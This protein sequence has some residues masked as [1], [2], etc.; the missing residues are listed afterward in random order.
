M[1]KTLDQ[2]RAEYAFKIVS[3]VTDKEYAS[4]FASLTSKMPSYILTNGLGNTLAFLFSKGKGHH[5]CIAGL[6]ADWILRIYRL[7]ESPN[8]Q[9]LTDDW[10]FDTKKIKNNLPEIMKGLVLS[11]D[12]YQYA[13]VTNE[14]LALFGW[15]KR[16]SD[17]MLEKG[18]K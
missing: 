18:G 14:L 2:R 1:A 10:I 13:V 8:I 9:A 15:L 17:G 5:L 3:Q 7:G 12:I 16:F 4:D 6:M 11:V